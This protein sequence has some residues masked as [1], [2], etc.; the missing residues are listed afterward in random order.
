MPADP[1]KLL[2]T[3]VAEVWLTVT[4]VSTINRITSPRAW[5]AWGLDRSLQVSGIDVQHEP[6]YAYGK[7]PWRI[8]KLPVTSPDACILDV[9][10]GGVRLLGIAST[11]SD[12]SPS[13]DTPAAN[14]AMKECRQLMRGQCGQGGGI[15]EE[16]KTRLTQNHRFVETLVEDLAFRW[17]WTSPDAD[18]SSPWLAESTS[19]F[20]HIDVYVDLQKSKCVDGKGQCITTMSSALSAWHKTGQFV[21]SCN[22]RNHYLKRARHTMALVDEAYFA[23]NPESC[24]IPMRIA[25]N[26]SMYVSASG[27]RTTG[28][29]YAWNLTEPH[30]DATASERD[31]PLHPSTLLA[32]AWHQNPKDQP[33]PENGVW[34]DSPG[35]AGLGGR[36]E[37]LMCRRADEDSSED[38]HAWGLHPLVAES[39]ALQTERLDPTRPG[40]AKTLSL[41]CFQEDKWEEN[42]RSWSPL[43]HLD[44]TQLDTMQ[45]WLVETVALTSRAMPYTE[46]VVDNTPVSTAD[47]VDSTTVPAADEV[48]STTVSTADSTAPAAD[49]SPGVDDWVADVRNAYCQNVAK[50]GPN[51]ITAADIFAPVG[52]AE[53]GGSK[54]W[55][56]DCESTN[57]HALKIFVGFRTLYLTLLWWVVSPASK[58]RNRVRARH[59][60]LKAPYAVALG[61]LALEFEPMLFEAGILTNIRKTVSS[62]M[63]T[64]DLSNW[65]ELQKKAASLPPSQNR[66]NYND[67]KNL[68]NSDIVP[69]LSTMLWPAA[70]FYGAASVGVLDRK[71]L[72]SDKRGS[73]APPP[74]GKAATAIRKRSPPSSEEPTPRGVSPRLVECTEWSA[75]F[76]GPDDENRG[77]MMPSTDRNRMQQLRKNAPWIRSTTPR[78]YLDKGYVVYNFVTSIIAP[79]M[80]LPSAL[81]GRGCGTFQVRMSGPGKDYEVD[82]N[83]R[84]ST[85]GVPLADLV[86]MGFKGG[87]L[88]ADTPFYLRA[89]GHQ[90]DTPK[91]WEVCLRSMRHAQGAQLPTFYPSLGPKL[92]APETAER[93]MAWCDATRQKRQTKLVETTAPGALTQF[94]VR[95]FEWASGLKQRVT[96]W[97]KKQKHKITVRDSETDEDVP[98]MRMRG[99]VIVVTLIFEG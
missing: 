90:T 12:T 63:S 10:E 28:L 82:Q 31:I 35:T 62:D 95:D 42:L 52:V 30:F 33:W 34:T 94:L 73:S 60:C 81:G 79:G 39:L 50:A 40:V 55:G 11:V 87:R 72:T 92:T 84:A 67:H 4:T 21:E 9:L 41:P 76:Q 97:A 18:T 53:V 48:S 45:A 26:K 37:E 49:S 14:A 27:Q 22:F 44:T 78:S 83:P 51:C 43:C 25:F 7:S 1:E 54:A 77:G 93:L 36:L 69:H 8:V 19:R 80:A 6:S 13:K 71:L 29:W 66:Y 2:R 23:L 46:D 5:L 70:D 99:Q 47:E 20:G 64:T 57:G 85:T 24:S 89:M 38:L 3:E 98:P 91:A 59:W 65:A 15:G 74:T 32:A 61:R 17:F 88:G 16:C 96:K 56:D 58:S 86:R 68:Y 75:S